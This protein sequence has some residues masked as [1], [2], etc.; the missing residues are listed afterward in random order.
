MMG[1]LHDGI[2]DRGIGSSGVCDGRG[3]ASFRGS[4]VSGSGGG[5]AEAAV[6]IQKMDRRTNCSS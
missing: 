3:G 1:E 5:G 2:G 4:S 6:V